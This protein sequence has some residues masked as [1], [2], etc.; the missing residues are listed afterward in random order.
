[1]RAGWCPMVEKSGT[2][3]LDTPEGDLTVMA[4]ADRVDV[5]PDGTEIL[6]FK[7]GKPPS[8]S[9]VYAMF[10]AQLPVIALIAANGGF[11]DP[12][13]GLPHDLRHIYVGGRNPKVEPAVHSKTSV[14]EL[15]ER[16]EYTLRKLSAI[17]HNPERP[18]LPKPRVRL[19]K[20]ATYDDPVDRLSRQAEWANAEDGE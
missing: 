20:S 6:D 8:A 13:I 10:G 9:E 11:D 19:I 3:T 4:R 2:L 14:Q 12:A 16:A 7:S 1:L 17:Y 5:G 18:Y 15:V